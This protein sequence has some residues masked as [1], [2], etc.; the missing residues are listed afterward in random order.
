MG[1]D[2]ENFSHRY[3]AE[4]KTSVFVFDMHDRNQGLCKFAVGCR[5]FLVDA[6]FLWEEIGKIFLIDILRK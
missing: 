2:R 4:M 3:F 6:R 5:N 1:R